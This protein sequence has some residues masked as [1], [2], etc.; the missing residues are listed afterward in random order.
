MNS[1]LVAGAI[2]SRRRIFNGASDG[3]AIGESTRGHSF[4]AVESPITG[5]DLSPEFRIDDGRE[6]P[7]LAELASP[8]KRSALISPLSSW[9]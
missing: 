8:I 5:G 4:F 1:T 6:R 9:V 2:C 7:F 3:L